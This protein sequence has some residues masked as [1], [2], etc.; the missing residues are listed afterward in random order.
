MERVVV[1][2]TDAFGGPCHTFKGS[3][4]VPGLAVHK[5]LSGWTLTHLATGLRVAS[6]RRRADLVAVKP[7][8]SAVDWTFESEAAAP[9][10]AKA[11]TFQLRA[12]L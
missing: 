5:D 11:V 2:T 10:E 4:L 8:L 7:L 12:I 6:A 3:L 1:Q 9:P